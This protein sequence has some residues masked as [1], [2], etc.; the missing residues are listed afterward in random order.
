MSPL[1]SKAEIEIRK[2]EFLKP[3]NCR[4]AVP[5]VRFGSLADIRWFGWYVR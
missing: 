1:A 3:V 5:N 4:L 2:Q